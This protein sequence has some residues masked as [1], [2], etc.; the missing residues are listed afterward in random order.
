M[1]CHLFS[2]I[3]FSL[4]FNL[5]NLE[6]RLTFVS[7]G[8]SHLPGRFVVPAL[9]RAAVRG[10][11]NPVRNGGGLPTEEGY[12]SKVVQLCWSRASRGLQ[13][14][15]SKHISWKDFGVERLV[16]L[17]C[18]TILKLQWA[19]LG[20]FLV[21]GCSYENTW[22]KC[23]IQNW[24]KVAEH[25][26]KSSLSC[27]L[28]FRTFF[29]STN[30]FRPHFCWLIHVDHHWKI[31]DF[32]WHIRWFS[33]GFPME[34]VGLY[35]PCTTQ[36]TFVLVCGEILPSAAWWTSEPI[37]CR[38]W[39]FIVNS[40]P[41]KGRKVQLIIILVGFYFLIFLGTSKTVQFIGG[42]D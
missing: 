33:H 34:F 35:H 41:Q 21:N 18:L 16:S 32:L 8:A 24:I 5:Q 22:L 2:R 25:P 27:A 15:G 29:P 37:A 6:D 38:T 42:Y 20:F 36:V 10:E 40:K 9:G 23:L 12:H 28:G 31:S 13:S 26:K 7:L 39:E 17:R 4:D 19:S 30:P 14:A 1:M 11:P 3:F